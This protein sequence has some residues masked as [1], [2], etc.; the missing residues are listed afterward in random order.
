[1]ERFYE[2]LENTLRQEPTMHNLVIGDSGAKLGCKLDDEET[3][4]GHH[5]YGQ[6][7]E[8]V[9]M[10]LGFLLRNSS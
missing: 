2:E 3:E 9:E 8:K 4:L 6:R 7:N 1:M 10:F 5:V